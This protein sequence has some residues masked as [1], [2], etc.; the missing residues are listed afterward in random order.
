MHMISS[1]SLVRVSPH[2]VPDIESFAKKAKAHADQMMNPELKE[3]IPPEETGM[4]QEST[5]TV[6]A[7]NGG[8][9]T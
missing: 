3:P 4:K 9:C 8:D 6:Q 5:R 2:V 1:W 7:S